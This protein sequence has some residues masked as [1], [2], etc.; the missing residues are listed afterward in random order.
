MTYK[1]NGRR[2]IAPIFLKN[3]L[4]LNPKVDIIEKTQPSDHEPNLMCVQYQVN[5]N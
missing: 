4:L 5:Q 1:I 3:V 2:G